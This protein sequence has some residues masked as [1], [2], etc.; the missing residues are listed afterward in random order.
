MF[1]PANDDGSRNPDAESVA[2]HSVAETG[3]DTP[4]GGEPHSTPASQPRLSSESWH[5]DFD[6]QIHEIRSATDELE[7]RSRH[8]WD[9]RPSRIADSIKPVSSA[10]IS[11]AKLPSESQETD[12]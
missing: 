10:E 11:S 2:R 8:L 6:T 4:P 3:A 7:A 9:V 5:D 1:D 12:R